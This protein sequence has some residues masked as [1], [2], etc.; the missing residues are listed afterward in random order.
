[1]MIRVSC[2]GLYFFARRHLTGTGPEGCHNGRLFHII[3]E[4]AGPRG[5]GAGMMRMRKLLFKRWIRI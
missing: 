3:E 4:K 2:K 5:R 1:M